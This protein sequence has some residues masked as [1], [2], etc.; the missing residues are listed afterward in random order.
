MCTLSVRH[1]IHDECKSRYLATISISRNFAIWSPGA[2]LVQVYTGL[3]PVL[4]LHT[5]SDAWL[6]WDQLLGAK[7]SSGMGIL[8][9]SV[10]SNI[11]QEWVGGIKH[12]ISKVMVTRFLQVLASSD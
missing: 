3:E 1:N 4:R 7:R 8:L 2:G 5:E 11:E 6:V 9:S 12:S 10:L